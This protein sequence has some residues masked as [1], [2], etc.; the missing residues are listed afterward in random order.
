M[1]DKLTEELRAYRREL[2][3]YIRKFFTRLLWGGGIAK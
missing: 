2:E 3:L 1:D